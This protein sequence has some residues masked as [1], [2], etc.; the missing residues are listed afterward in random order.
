MVRG[1][2]GVHELR[3]G[4]PQR[5]HLGPEGHIGRTHEA[6]VVRVQVLEDESVHAARKG[7]DASRGRVVRR[8]QRI[9][10]VEGQLKRQATPTKKEKKK[11]NDQSF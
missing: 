11:R 1:H 6:V 8:G 10:P 2:D 7:L 9:L 5:E 4:S 3:L